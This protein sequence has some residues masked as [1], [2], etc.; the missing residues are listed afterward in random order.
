MYNAVGMPTSIQAKKGSSTLLNISYPSIDTH[1]N[2]RERKDLYKSLSESFT[3]DDMNRLTTGVTYSANGNITSK[4]NVGSYQYDSNHPH[5][6]KSVNFNGA[7]E[8]NN[9][10]LLVTYIVSACPFN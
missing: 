9:S 1:Q 7:A 2:I 3:Y 6:V 10:D 8:F 4:V 5:A